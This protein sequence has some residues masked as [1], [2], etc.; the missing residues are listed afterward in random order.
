MKINPVKIKAT[1][2]WKNNASAAFVRFLMKTLD[3]KI[4]EDM[5]LH[6]G[7]IISTLQMDEKLTEIELLNLASIVNKNPKFIRHLV[8]HP[9]KQVRYITMFADSTY[10]HLFYKEHVG[11][12][13]HLV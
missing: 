7:Y 9:A 2:F 6:D 3:L 1:F 4:L 10:L 12:M 5:S 8:Q 11:R 13:L